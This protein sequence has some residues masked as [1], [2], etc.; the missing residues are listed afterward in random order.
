MTRISLQ[1][2]LERFHLLPTRMLFSSQG[3]PLFPQ[4]LCIDLHFHLSRAK[5]WCV[6]SNEIPLAWNISQIPISHSSLTWRVSDG[7]SCMTVQ[8]WRLGQPG[9]INHISFFLSLASFPTKSHSPQTGRKNSDS[10]ISIDP[11]HLP[12][13]MTIISAK[14]LLAV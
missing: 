5:K 3:L 9:K 4:Q 10:D 7:Y 6:K 14:V 13:V 12:G 1:W 11:K 2:F 8:K